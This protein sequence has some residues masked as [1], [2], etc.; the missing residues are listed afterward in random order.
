M[1]DVKNHLAA[2]RSDVLAMLNGASPQTLRRLIKAGKFPPPITFG[3][4]RIWPR[5][6]L[7]QWLEREWASLG[8]P[9]KGPTIA[10]K[11]AGGAAK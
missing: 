11:T 3:R 7:E 9:G 10:G 6:A 5:A 2:Q 4:A 8:L 1:E